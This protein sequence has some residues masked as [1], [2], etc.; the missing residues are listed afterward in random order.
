MRSH[1]RRL[2]KKLLGAG[3]SMQCSVS[4]NNSVAANATLPLEPLVRI[5]SDNFPGRR[6]ALVRANLFMVLAPTLL[7]L[8]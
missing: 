3:G 4:G 7:Y 5:P 8:K 2:P 6:E 1:E